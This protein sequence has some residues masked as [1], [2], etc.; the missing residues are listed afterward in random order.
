MV[1]SVLNDIRSK[2]KTGVK[3]PAGGMVGGGH[4]SVV[5]NNPRRSNAIS[6]PQD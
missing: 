1:L 3:N 4:P 5:H 6:L 2:K